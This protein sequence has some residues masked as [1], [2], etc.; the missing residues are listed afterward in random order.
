MEIY[1]NISF[2]VCRILLLYVILYVMFT[3]LYVIIPF[4]I[5]MNLSEG[6]AIA[7]C[8]IT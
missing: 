5:H 4:Y 2:A 7:V 8:V 3:M 6:G 1:F